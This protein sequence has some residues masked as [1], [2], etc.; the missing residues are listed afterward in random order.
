MRRLTTLAAVLVLAAL[1]SGMLGVRAPTAPPNS[2]VYEACKPGA[3][4]VRAADLPRLVDQRRCPV[5][6]RVIVDGGGLGIALPE[7]GTGIFAEALTLTG[8]SHFTVFN[9]RGEA[10]VLEDVGDEAAVSGV[11]SSAVGSRREAFAAQR[12][13]SSQGCNDGAHRPDPANRG[14]RL[15]GDLPWYFDAGSTPTGLS[16]DLVEQQV[17]LAGQNITRVDNPCGVADG[18][19][20]EMPY[21]G[22]TERSVD[23]SAR[24]ECLRRD[25]YSVVGFGDLREGWLA[26][27]CAKFVAREGQDEIAISDIKMNK[28]DGVRWTVNITDSCR[29][30][31]DVQG[32]MTHERGH[33]FGM[34]HVGEEQHP[35]LTMSEL[36]TA[37]CSGA[38]RSLGLGDARGL[39]EKY[40]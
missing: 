5:A 22:R 35:A 8:S 39:N 20:I 40:P 26:Y 12:T 32:V 19:G 24:G 16:V 14:A 34:M 25:A 27:H 31:V 37:Y 17:A 33:G 21:Q 7:P 13:S 6:G 15:Y 11:S 23:I 18:V 2:G 29:G 3:E 28:G 30:K 10:F 4:R 9:A 36:I 1:A 38:E